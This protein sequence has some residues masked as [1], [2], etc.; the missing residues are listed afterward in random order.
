MNRRAVLELSGLA[1][2]VLMSGAVQAAAP[3]KR[4]LGSR[5]TTRDGVGLH[6]SDWGPGKVIVFVHSWALHSQMWD[7]QVAAFTR[8]GVKGM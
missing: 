5:V 4:F 3:P 8:A 1:A 2:G 7:Y 6:F